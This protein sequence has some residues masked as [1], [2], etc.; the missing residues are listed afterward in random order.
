[1]IGSRSGRGLNAL[2]RIV[3]EARIFWPSSGS[4]PGPTYL[5]VDSGTGLAYGYWYRLKFKT[6]LSGDI[7]LKR[8][9]SSTIKPKKGE[10]PCKH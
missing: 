9:F 10:K 6:P 7:F 5:F 2:A 8:A 4:V 3:K 1:M